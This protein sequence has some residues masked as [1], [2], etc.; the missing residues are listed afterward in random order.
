MK[1]SLDPSNTADWSQIRTL[2]KAGG[3]DDHDREP[4]ARVQP[5]ASLEVFW[6]SHRGGRWSV[7][8]NLLNRSTKVWGTPQELGT[9]PYSMRAPA[10]FTNGTDSVLVFRSSEYVPT[11]NTTGATETVDD[12]YS[13]S[14]TVDTR[15]TA[16][17]ALRGKFDDFGTYVYD[18]GRGGVR[19]NDDWYAR[20]TIGV[21]LAASVG[22]DDVS[23]LN[24]VLTEFMPATD[25]AVFVKDS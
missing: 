15:H 13:G 6:S 17:L 11:T 7:W 22:D 1:A 18:A 24:Q 2:P 8:R 4:S 10:A 16:K 9:A 25:R 14:T 3:D 20:D 19:T 12:R 23:R 5:G 21:Y